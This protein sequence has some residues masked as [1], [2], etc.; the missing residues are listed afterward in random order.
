MLLAVLLLFY[1]TLWH[2]DA[3]MFIPALLCT[4]SWCS[5]SWRPKA[6]MPCLVPNTSLSIQPPSRVQLSPWRVG[7]SCTTEQCT[8]ASMCPGWVTPCKARSAVH[9]LLVVS[10][11]AGTGFLLP[12]ERCGS[13]VWKMQGNVSSIVIRAESSR[14][15]CTVMPRT[16]QRPW[17]QQQQWWQDWADRSQ[18]SAWLTTVQT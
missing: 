18:F 6:S 17:A 7:R 16:A 1:I 14:E 5:L 9:I 2:G 15:G 3:L 11:A 13:I 4:C 12:S 8:L 10:C